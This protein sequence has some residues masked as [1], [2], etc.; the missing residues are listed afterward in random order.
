M[1]GQYSLLDASYEATER[2]RKIQF[3]LSANDA[4]QDKVVWEVFLK[5]LENNPYFAITNIAP[6]VLD[7]LFELNVEGGNAALRKLVCLADQPTKIPNLNCL[8]SHRL[9]RANDK[10]YDPT[11]S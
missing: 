10:Q 9:N 4:S 11:P 1:V 2:S 8:P 6:E 3:A 5:G 7:G